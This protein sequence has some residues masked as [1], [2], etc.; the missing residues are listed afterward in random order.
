MSFDLATTL[1]SLPAVVIGLT[2]HEYAHARAAYALGDP[3][4]MDEGRLTLN[5]LKHIDPLGFLFLAVA[6]FGWA[7]PVRFSRESL[8]DPRRGGSPS[9]PSPTSRSKEAPSAPWFS[10]SW[11][12]S[13]T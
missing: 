11:S 8:R 6:G 3:T 9:W 10:S 2:I 5:P 7:R 1:Y 12:T 13:S 4:A